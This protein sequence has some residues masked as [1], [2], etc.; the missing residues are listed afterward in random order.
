MLA[1]GKLQK[2][3]LVG[4]SMRFPLL[5]PASPSSAST[6]LPSLPSQSDFTRRKSCEKKAKSCDFLSLGSFCDFLSLDPILCFPNRRRG[7]K[8]QRNHQIYTEKESRQQT[9]MRSKGRHFVILGRLP[10]LRRPLKFLPLSCCES[11][12]DLYLQQTFPSQSNFCVQ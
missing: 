12:N 11:F 7:T 5:P 10:V 9:E 4:T 2:H 6:L 1:R 8:Q 3:V